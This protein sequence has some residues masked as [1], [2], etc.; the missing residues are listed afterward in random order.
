MSTKRRPGRPRGA[1]GSRERIVAAAVG[2]FGEHGYDGATIRAIAARAEVDPALVHH[3]FGSKADLFADVAGFPVRPDVAVPGILRGPR[4]QA[5]ERIVRF[6]LEAFERPDV[7]GRGVMLIRS[8]VGGKAA[9]SLVTA[10]LTRE[11]LPRIARELDVPDAELRAALVASQ[12]VGLLVARH[13][14]RVPATADAT[15]DELVAR[16]GPTVQR[17]LFE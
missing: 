2:E 16:V 11:L 9:S 3:Y 10:F 1:S 14:V 8:V 12:I 6:V 15:V 17:Y 5:G 13:V 4:D 7:R